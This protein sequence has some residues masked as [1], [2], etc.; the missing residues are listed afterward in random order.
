MTAMILVAAVQA[1]P[2][3][4]GR[5]FR[6][7]ELRTQPGYQVSVFARTNGTPRMMAFG[8]NGVLYA[9][10]RG[11]GTIVAIPRE[12][13]VVTVL[14]GLRGPHTVLFRGNDLYVMVNDGLLRYRDAVSDD[15]VVRGAPERLLTVPTGGH[16]TRT[17]GFSPVGKLFVTVGSSCNFCMESDQR[18]AAMMR[19]ELDGSG[20]TV[21]ARGLRNS[22]GFAWHPVTGELWATDNGGDGLGDDVP[23]EEINIIDAGADYGWPDCEGDRREVDWG[24]AARRGRCGATRAPAFTTVAHSAPLGISF[25]TGAQF[26]ASFLNDAL[27]ALHGSWNRNEPSGAKVIRVR[28]SAGRPVGEEDFLWGF[29]D[30]A[31]RTRSG[32]PVHALTGPDGAVYVSD[33]GNG[34]IYRVTYIGPRISPGGIARNSGRIYELYG[35]NLVGNSGEFAILCNGSP[36]ET[37]YVS[38]IQVN[39]VVPEGLTGDVTVSVKND[40]AGDES[41]IRID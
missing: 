9:A 19:Y 29:Y 38:S 27:V 11:L 8:P 12:N 14:S 4:G 31:T 2:G 23:P 34:N 17:L 40:K 6:L 21:Y 18:R 3:V 7:E 22:V 28:S 1:Q 41:V 10:V 35:S 33:D 32:R 5:P 20:E 15:L 30:A 13:Q 39:F 24:P 26:P 36:A 37:L 25:Y 16:D